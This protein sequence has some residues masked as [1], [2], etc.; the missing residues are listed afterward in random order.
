MN[1]RLKR[2]KF[3]IDSKV[4]KRMKIRKIKYEKFFQKKL[5]RFN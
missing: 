3:F 5:F 4:V 2:K 1:E